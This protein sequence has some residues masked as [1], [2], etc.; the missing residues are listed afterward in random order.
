EYAIEALPRIIEKYPNVVYIVLGATH[1][2]LLRTDGEMYRLSLQ[3]LAKK[4]GVEENVIFQNRFVSL[5]DL[6]EYISAADLYI[7]PYLNR[8]QLV[9]GTLAYTVGA[10]KAVV[11]TP[12]WYAEEILAEGRGAIVPE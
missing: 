11:S 5:D 8:E 4:R 6:I 7:T 10:G 3:R 12:L 9:S 1:P 2:H